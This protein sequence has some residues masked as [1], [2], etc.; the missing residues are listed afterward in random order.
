[1]LRGARLVATD[2][3]YH[4][5]ARGNIRDWLFQDEVD[6]QKYLDLCRR[7]KEAYGLWIYH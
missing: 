4:V 6:F 5:A 7:Y 1:M 2:L 3:V